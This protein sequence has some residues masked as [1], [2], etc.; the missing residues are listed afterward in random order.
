MFCEWETSLGL[1]ILQDFGGTGGLMCKK[2]SSFSEWDAVV[3][4]NCGV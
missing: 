1:P 4:K 3:K 2:R